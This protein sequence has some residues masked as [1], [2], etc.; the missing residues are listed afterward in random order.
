MGVKANCHDNY[1][2]FYCKNKQVRRSL[3]GIGARMCCVIDGLKCEL[4]TPYEKPKYFPT[5]SPAPRKIVINI[6]LRIKKG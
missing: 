1:D 6:N 3:C 4:Q 2:G 5:Y